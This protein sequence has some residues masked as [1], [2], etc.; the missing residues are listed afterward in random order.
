MSLL[1]LWIIYNPMTNVIDVKDFLQ[2]Y[3]V[4]CAEDME[5]KLETMQTITISLTKENSKMP[6]EELIENF[7]LFKKTKNQVERKK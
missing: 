6:K 7:N 1:N 2:H 5:R 4:D 3:N